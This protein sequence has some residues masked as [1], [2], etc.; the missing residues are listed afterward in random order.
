[1]GFKSFRGGIHPPTSKNLTINKPF[2][3][4]SIPHICYIPLLQHIGKPADCIVKVGDYIQEGAKIGSA[5]GKVSANIHASIPGKVIDI[6][7]HPTVFGKNSL[8]VV[9]EAEG[10]FSASSSKQSLKQISDL[11]KEEILSTIFESGIV[12]LGGAAFPT[13]IKLNP[14]VNSKIDLLIINGAECEPYLTNDNQLMQTYPE[15]LVNGIIITMKALNVSKAMIGI[16]DNKKKAIKSLKD[17][18]LTAGYQNSI[19]V[20]QVPTKYPQGAEKQ[21]IKTLTKRI[22]PSGSL[23]MDV[24]VVVQNIGTIYAIFEAVMHDK[25]LIE[26]FVTIS[27]SIVK[28]PGNY[29]IRIGTK[30]S[31]VMTE[32]GIK[33]KPAKIIMG[34]PMCGIAIDNTDIPVIKGTS[35]LIFLSKN[36]I[37]DNSYESCIRCGRCVSVCPMNLT[38]YEIGRAVEIEQYALA[39][40][41][42]PFDCIMCGSCSYICP[43]RRPLSHFI[44]LAQ[45][46]LRKK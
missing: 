39:E 14:P 3:N 18:V 34:G 22:V 46:K 45:Q 5:S 41:L 31:D 16:E 15:Q 20:C 33:E 11:T 36:E 7:E 10:A 24:G 27:G 6:K 9:I 13:S 21:L 19:E 4:H 28:Q 30:I 44:K 29:K 17:A 35:G 26:R 12:G 37:C 1:M 40:K 38:P 8:C 43:A 42:N 23:P 25:P 2:I 32:C